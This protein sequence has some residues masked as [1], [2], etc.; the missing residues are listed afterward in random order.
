MEPRSRL[1]SI[2]TGA[3]Q[4]KQAS[5]ALVLAGSCL[6]R[7][8]LVRKNRLIYDKRQFELQAR[9]VALLT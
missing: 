8:S 7:G 6:A 2:T 3:M 9:V 5:L 1:T 4:V